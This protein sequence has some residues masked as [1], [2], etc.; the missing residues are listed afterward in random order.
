MRARIISKWGASEG[1]EL[2]FGEEVTIGRAEGNG[3]V[4]EAPSISSQHARIAFDAERG[5][6][7]VEDLGSLN[8]T[9]LDGIRITRPEPLRRLH[10]IA[11]GGACEFIF[12]LLSAE[13]EEEAAAAPVE[14]ATMVDQDIPTLPLSLADLDA[15]LDSTRIDSEAPALP[16]T[17]ALG[18]GA[19]AGF[20]LETRPSEGSPRRLPLKPGEN[21]LGRTEETPLTLASPHVSRRHAILTVAGERVT[22]R[23]LGSHNHTFLEGKRIDE[24]TEVRPGALL[25]FGDVEAVLL[26]ADR[27]QG[28]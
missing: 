1:T 5:C 26:G 2:T 15:D 24:E 27:D 9:E 14:E 19:A 28:K 3:L 20:L 25:R 12:Q 7:L 8:G 13:P 21:V 17:L 22:V 10:V 11:F 6:Y 16:A 18:A 23:D 4:L